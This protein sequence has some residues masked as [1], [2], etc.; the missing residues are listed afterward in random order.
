MTDL[1][2]E[3]TAA[4][5]LVHRHRPATVVLRLSCDRAGQYRLA[6]DRI[7]GARLVE[8]LEPQREDSKS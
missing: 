2:D 8:L 5:K 7:E 6:L 3:F 4:L 1:S